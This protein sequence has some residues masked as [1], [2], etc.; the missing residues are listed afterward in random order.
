MNI[1]EFVKETLMQVSNAANSVLDSEKGQY[2]DRNVTIH[3]DIAVAATD[4]TDVGGGAS[5]QVASI[6]KVG[7]NTDKVQSVKEYSRIS[8]DLDFNMYN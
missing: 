3:F 5:L 4:T 6:L 2:V 7:G 1:E 8:F